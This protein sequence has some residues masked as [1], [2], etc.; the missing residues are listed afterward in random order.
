MLSPL[1]YNEARRCAFKSFFFGMLRDLTGRSEES[2]E[3]PDGAR[4]E[5]VFDHYASQFPRL[6]EM[7]SSIVLARNQ[8]FAGPEAVLGDGDEV[9]LMPPVSGGSQDAGPGPNGASA[10]GK[11]SPWLASS[12]D[13]RGFYALTKDPID[14]E[15]L[16]RRVITAADG[17]II[18]FE[19]VVRGHSDGRRTR[20]LDYDCYVPLAL[21]KM[22]EIG[23]EILGKHPVGRIAMVHRLGRLEI[24]EASVA[25]VVSSAHRRPAYEASLE[26]ISRL[27]KLVPVWKKEYFEDGEVWVEGEWETGVP[28]TAGDRPA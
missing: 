6:R 20:F 23:R 27:K 2:L 21:R 19:G 15:Q 22:Q 11:S 7:A 16:R 25:I 28:R 1:R 12:E 10:P 18:A 26:A 3:L 9:A 17:A 4:L 13:E 8:E 14:V 24:S 5:T